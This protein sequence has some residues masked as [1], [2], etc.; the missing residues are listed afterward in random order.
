MVMIIVGAIV[1]SVSGVSGDKSKGQNIIFFAIIGAL[2]SWGS[3][4][5]INFVVDNI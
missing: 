2:I 3:W 1:Y 5:I 4:F